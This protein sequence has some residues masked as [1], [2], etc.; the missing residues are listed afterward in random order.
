MKNIIL[1]TKA[2][3]LITGFTGIIT[4]HAKYLTGCDQYCLKPQKLGKDGELKD[5]VWFDV[6]QI[7]VV[8]EKPL[9]INTRPTGGPRMDCAPAK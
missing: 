7:E 9:K 8:D 2:K 1:G 5:G 3:C 6:E 4:A